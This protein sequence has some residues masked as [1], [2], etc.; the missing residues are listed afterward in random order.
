MMT[1]LHARDVV[2]DRALAFS[3]AHHLVLWHEQER[4]LLVDESADQPGTRD[5]IDARFL[6]GDPLHA[7]PLLAAVGLVERGLEGL[8]QLHRVVVRPEVHVEEA[9]H[10][11]EAWLWIAVTSTPCCRS[12]LATAFTS[13]SI[14][15][16]SPVI[17]AFPSLVGWKFITVTTPM[18]GSSAW[19][20]SVIAS[21]RGTVTWKTPAPTSR[22]ERPSACSMAFVSRVGPPA[23]AEAGA[24]APSGVPLA[25][26]AWRRARAICTASPCPL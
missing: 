8:R 20:I 2:R 16:K 4:R 17:A 25:N 15:T 26:S 10:V 7:S 14:S 5:S 1:E 22:P 11:H 21:A 23:A 6:T 24:G 3:N 9:G 12:V 19:P 13:L 18:A